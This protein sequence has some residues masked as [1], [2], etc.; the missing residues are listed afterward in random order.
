MGPGRA[1]RRRPLWMRDSSVDASVPRW[2]R[3][4]L[5]HPFARSGP[6]SRLGQPSRSRGA[7]PVREGAG[8]RKA[9]GTNVIDTVQLTS[10]VRARGP[11]VVSRGWSRGRSWS[12]RGPRARPATRR[13]GVADP[14]TAAA[15]KL[16]GAYRPG[17]SDSRNFAN[18]Y[19]SPWLQGRCQNSQTQWSSA[20][21]SL[22]HQ[23]R[24]QE[25]A[26]LLRDALRVLLVGAMAAAGQ[27]DEGG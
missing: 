6:P 7:V 2:T 14:D 18:Y 11:L 16:T 22:Q 15:T 12:R 25:G 20:P 27:L 13:S 1:R 26:D 19:S 4:P 8:S 23:P 24:F 5:S 9:I 3:F 10:Y 21:S 17:R